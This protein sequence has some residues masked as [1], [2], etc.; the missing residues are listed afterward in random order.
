MPSRSEDAS[1]RRAEEM[2]QAM[3]VQSF[4][5]RTSSQLTEHG[6]RQ[7]HTASNGSLSSCLLLNPHK[8]NPAQLSNHTAASATGA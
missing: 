8:T 7:L 6:L 4:F 3:L 5:Q 2:H 1:A